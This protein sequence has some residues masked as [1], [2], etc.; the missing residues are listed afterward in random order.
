MVG[1]LPRDFGFEEVTDA[2]SEIPGGF[3]AGSN[4]ANR[5]IRFV[6]QDAFV[7]EDLAEMLL[8]RTSALGQVPEKFTLRDVGYEHGVTPDPPPLVKSYFDAVE[9]WKALKDVA[10]YKTGDHMLHF[11][12]GHD[13][14]ACISL[15]Y[16]VNDLMQL[17]SLHAFIQDIAKAD[18][19]RQEKLTIAR[20][21]IVEQF[22]R[23]GC[24]RV[25]EVIRGF[26]HL[27]MYFRQ[28]YALFLADFSTAKVRREVE[29]QNLD[30]ALRLNK[31]LAEIQNQLLALPAALLVAGATVDPSSA[32]KNVAVLAGTAIFVVLMWLLIGNQNNS[33]EAIGTEIGLR[34]ELL[35]AQPEGI[36]DQY[37]GAFASLTRRVKTQTDVLLVIRWLVVLVFLLTTYMATDALAGGAIS[38]YWSGVVSGDSVKSAH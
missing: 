19:H 9:L 17:P 8:R 3:F 30:D 12:V 33:V 37:K 16:G 21:G 1:V 26:E 31:T 38:D 14:E 25:G 34:R 35:E 28:S 10:S 7:Y 5:E 18:L 36:A 13:K 20:A 11:V 15:H 4:R 2:L 22:S 27:M 29:K 6:P 24:A 23:D 32:A